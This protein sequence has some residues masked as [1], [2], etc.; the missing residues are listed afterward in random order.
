MFRRIVLA[1]VTAMILT[2]TAFIGYHV[3]QLS[4]SSDPNVQAQWKKSKT[5]LISTIVL[6]VTSMTLVGL[7]L[8][9]GGIK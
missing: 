8:T 4:Q 9:M 7:L 6:N 2:A 3:Y 1:V 5:Y